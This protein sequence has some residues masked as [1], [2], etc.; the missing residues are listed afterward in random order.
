MS[1]ARRSIT[2]RRCG[3]IAHRRGRG[4]RGVRGPERRRLQHGA[5]ADGDVH[6]EPDERGA[7]RPPPADAIISVGDTIGGYTF[8]SIPDGVAI[9]ARGNGRADVYVNHETST[10]PFPFAS[11]W[12]QL[13]P[14]PAPPAP[15]ATPIPEANQNDFTNS[16]V[17]LLTF[18]RH[19][20]EINQASKAIASVENYQRFCSNY[21]ATAIEGFKKPILF[22][23]EEAQDWVFRSGTAW[24]G[25]T[26]ITPGYGRRRAGRRRRRPR[27][28]ERQD[29]DDLRHGPAQP[30]EQRRGPGF[31]ELV[32]LS[33]DDTFQTNPPASSQLYMY[34]AARRGQALGRRGH[35]PRLRRRRDGQRLLRPPARRDDQRELRAR[36]REHRE[37]QG[38]GRPRAD[39]RSTSR[40]T[41]LRQ[42]G[43]PCRRMGRSGSSTSG[44]TSPT[45]RASRPA[46]NV[47]DFIRIEDIAYDKRPDMSNVVYIADSGRATRRRSANPLT[48]VDERAHLQDGARRE[49]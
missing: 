15:P 26:S 36:A 46:T 4:E 2:C 3:R 34:T 38:C 5:G 7:R 44:A 9:L 24:P 13:G 39:E 22:T 27:R 8:E 45:R 17:S 33:G 30:R 16:E 32:V 37:G 11:P 42:A 35:A 28:E 25:P 21:L 31:D 48:S 41:R 40:A 10:V 18:N 47:F 23:N 12:P 20:V 14:P 49:R 43:P 1:S 6:H 19:K 29:E